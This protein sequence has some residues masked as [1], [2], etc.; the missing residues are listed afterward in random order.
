MAL[1]SH[2]DW[3]S[4]QMSGGLP[5]ELVRLRKRGMGWSKAPVRQNGLGLPCLARTDFL[6]AGHQPIKTIGKAERPH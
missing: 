3:K 4:M 6:V 2:A 1:G 5:P